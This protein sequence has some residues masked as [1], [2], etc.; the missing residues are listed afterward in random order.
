MS[1]K[2][3]LVIVE[4][5]AKAKTIKKYLGNNFEVIACFGHIR[6]LPAKRFGVDVKNDFTPEYVIIKDKEKIVSEIKEKAKN[7][8]SV[9]LATDPDREGEAISWHLANILKLNSDD[10]NRVA[11]NEI[12]K[13]GVK[14]GIE[15]PRKIDSDLVDAQ[16]ARRILDRLVGYKLSPF[17]CQRIQ[18]GLSGGRVQSVALRMIVDRENEIR[19]FVPEEYWTITASL[20]P[21]KSEKVFQAKFWGNKDGEIKLKNQSQTNEILEHIKDSEY[22]IVKL[23]KGK[24]SKNPAPPFITS[25]FQQ[26]A[27][28][29]LGFSSKRAMKVAQELYE[30]VDISGHGATGLITYMRT[31]S[32]RISDEAMAEAKDFIIKTW[33][34]KY[35][36]TTQRKF[37]TKANAQDAH[38]AIR[39]TVINF[40]P[41]EIKS[42]L[43]NDQF[44]IYK[45]VWNRFIASQMTNCLQDTVRVEIDAS[46]YIFRASGLTVSFDGFTV[47]YSEGKDEK[48]EQE[49]S[50]PKLSEGMNCGLKKLDHAQHFTEPPPR[51]TEASLIKALEENGVGRPSTYAATISVLIFREYVT[52]DGKI[53]SPTELGETVDGLIKK[54]FPAIVNVEFTAKMES[55]LDGVKHGKSKWQNI[56][57]DFYGDFEKMLENAKAETK[58]LKLELKENETDIICEKCGNKMV[59]RRGRYGKFIGCSG[60][61]E[62]KNIQKIIKTVGAKCPKCNGEIIEKNTKRNRI[63]YGCANYPNCNFA[64]WDTPTDQVCPKC[65]SFLFKKGED[66]FCITCDSHPKT[67]DL[68]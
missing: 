22:K 64:T 42:S 1:K 34:E 27:V 36:P 11:F 10:N 16:Q 56:L 25:T 65:G 7:S 3:N 19:I 57:R 62:C 28:R 18:K 13:T 4:S 52:K 23:K 9:V 61:P 33:G 53:F 43:T 14:K 24:R 12:T 31:D 35:S 30:G 29:K 54:Y 8:V 45:L 68:S 58:D 60:Y 5:P 20:N 63:F 50:L 66:I 2:N 55:Q 59:I 51:F 15:T 38:E 46:G 40:L 48:E 26:E 17:L 21:E 6:D 37:K 44:K 47:L 32:I 67:S 39:P 41:E 49:K